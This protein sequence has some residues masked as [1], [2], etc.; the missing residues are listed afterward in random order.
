MKC[1]NCKAPIQANETECEWCNFIVSEKKHNSNNDDSK[2]LNK[3]EGLFFSKRNTKTKCFYELYN[4]GIKIFDADENLNL[5][6]KKEIIFNIEP[7]NRFNLLHFMPIIGSIIRFIILIFKKYKKGFT[8]TTSKSGKNVLIVKN[9][10]Y[11]DFKK[12]IDNLL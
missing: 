12:A 2:L 1:P 7:F 4:T 8:I 9:V 5:F 11:L 6:I 10:N 3:G